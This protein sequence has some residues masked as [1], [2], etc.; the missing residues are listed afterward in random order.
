MVCLKI[1]IIFCLQ[2]QFED[3]CYWCSSSEIRYQTGG[4]TLL[5]RKTIR[6]QISNVRSIYQS[7]QAFVKDAGGTVEFS[8][9]GTFDKS[10]DV[11]ISVLGG[12][13]CKGLVIFKC[14]F[15]AMIL[16]LKSTGKKSKDNIPVLSIFISE[17]LGCE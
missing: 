8:K 7:I 17:D 11:V 9:N 14:Y 10:C 4:W 13:L 2:P 6:I 5:A 16:P 12:A 15:K 3:W 1:I